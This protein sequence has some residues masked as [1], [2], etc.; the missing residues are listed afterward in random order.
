[1][2]ASSDASNPE[3]QDEV[4]PEE[5]DELA[6]PVK[7]DRLQPWHRPR[8]Q[9]IR[10]KLWIDFS[11]RLIRKEKN[12]PGLPI[13]AVGK[14]EVR[15]LTL[16][17][18]DYLDVRMLADLCSEQ[19]CYLTSV[20]FL[21][22]DEN[23]NPDIARA[24]VRE[25]DL[26]S[27]N[28]I[29]GSSVTYYRRFEEI[30]DKGQAYRN[31]QHKGPFHIVN[32]DACGPLAPPTAEH[33]TRL[34]DAIYR[35]VEFQLG[36][37]SSR[38][39]LFISA[40]IRQT[41]FSQETLSKLCK[42]IFKN[43]E[44]NEA[45][46]EKVLLMFGENGVEIESVI[47]TAMNSSGEEFLKLFALSLSKWLL[48]LANGKNWNMTTHDTYCYATGSSGNYAP[49]MVSLAFEFMPPQHGLYDPHSVARA[50]PAVDNEPGDTSIQAANKVADMENVDCRMKSCHKLR[51]KMTNQVRKLLEEAHYDPATLGELE[52][53]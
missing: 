16:P 12:L 26:I 46:R 21:S 22:G 35:I 50:Q 14:P 29:T 49:T 13:P 33:A 19:D 4:L 30:A 17:G 39:L 9:F 1:M 45:F 20:G 2:T 48:H 18:I 6:V 31:L 5:P 3:I 37:K 32:I 47:A 40:N 41:S 28:I 43:A 23:T 8:K 53:Y 34:I 51:E 25:F 52:R 10:K 42:A 24:K 15:Y 27:T 7:L 36:N 44:N 38:W 11:K